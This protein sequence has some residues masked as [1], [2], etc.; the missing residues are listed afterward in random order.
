ME[1]FRGYFEVRKT[2]NELRSRFGR[3][4]SC[5]VVYSSEARVLRSVFWTRMERARNSNALF[6]RMHKV[7]R[8]IQGDGLP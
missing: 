8:S 7:D 3:Q 1:S 4:I 6:R 5:A 2:L